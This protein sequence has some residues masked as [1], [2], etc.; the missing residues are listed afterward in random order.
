MIHRILITLIL[1]IPLN[2]AAQERREI[3]SFIELGSASD[4][5]RDS[6]TTSVAT[7]SEAWHSLDDAALIQLHSKDT[8]WMNAYARIIRG[9]APLGDFISN[10][11]FPD[12]RARGVTSNLSLQQ[13][14][15]RYLNDTTAISHLYTD[16]E[17]GGGAP[18]RTHFH[19]V[20]KKSEDVWLIEH[21]AIMDAR[22]W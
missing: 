14:S 7:Y 10:K 13:I 5:S 4:D 19:L 17:I 22:D 8:E 9:R 15:L 6:L 2:L 1:V 16:F 3:P 11:L 18:R 12:F 20:W 21:T